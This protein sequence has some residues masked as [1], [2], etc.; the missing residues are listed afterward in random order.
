M[1]DSTAIQ[2][3]DAALASGYLIVRETPQP[4]GFSTFAAKSKSDGSDVE[5]K[6]VPIGI[7]SGSGA[8][9]EVAAAARKLTHPNI[10]PIISSGSYGGTFY[11]ISPAIEGR[12]LRDRLARGGRIAAEDALTV[13]R[14]LSAALTHAHLHGVVHG[15]LSPDSVLLSGGSALVS[16]FGISEMFAALR[17]A[18]AKR[19]TATPTGGESLRYASPEEAGGAKS[20]TR[21]DA[22]AWGVIAY[23]ILAGRHPFAAR[24]TP[25]EVAAAHAGE[26]PSPLAASGTTI[27]PGVTRLIMRC[28]SKDP[29]D[30]PETAREILDSMTR[31]LLLPPPE[32]AAGTGQKAAIVLMVL[33][34][35]V[36]VLM[37]WLG[38]RS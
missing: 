30:R 13:L 27:T 11:W 2:D 29:Q 24:R 33:A 16:D 3:L 25:R 7:F 28:L 19:N 15:G 22:Y 9:I 17:R 18:D 14:D 26:T 1:H 12:T 5:I 35:T 6:T 32:P 37:A 8:V 34:V 4:A 31:E 10:V 36:I 23:E 20:D 21:S 38:L